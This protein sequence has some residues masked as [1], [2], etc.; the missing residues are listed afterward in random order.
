MLD[1]NITDQIGLQFSLDKPSDWE[2]I[3]PE[4]WTYANGRRIW[5]LNGHLGA[6]KTTMVKYL[7][8]FLGSTCS[9]DS[10][11]FSLV[12]EYE[13]NGADTISKVY[14]IDLYRLNST[15]EAIDIGLE[16][17]LYGESLV[18]IE[19]PELASPLLED[20]VVTINIQNEKG[21]R[22]IVVL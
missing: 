6:G 16:E 11:T 14:H 20:D 8:A 10:P 19:W 18:L 21:V 15:D 3:I 13:T 7:M 17:I 12:N 4:I 9:V 5:L 1:K 2:R 22:N